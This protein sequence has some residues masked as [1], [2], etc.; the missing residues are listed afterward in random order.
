[1]VVVLVGWLRN[2]PA[3]CKCIPGT[4]WLWRRDDDDNE[5]DPNSDNGDDGV[6]GN[7]DDDGEL[8]SLD[9]V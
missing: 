6:D 9:S 7:D 5:D 1:M 4:E 2:V 3:T 8:L